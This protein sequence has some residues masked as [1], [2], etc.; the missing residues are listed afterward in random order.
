MMSSL[1]YRLT[2][3]KMQEQ[4]GDQQGFSSLLFI[5]EKPTAPSPPLR[6]ANWQS[7]G[8]YATVLCL[9]ISSKGEV[10]QPLNTIGE[11]RTV[12]RGRGVMSTYSI[13]EVVVCR[14]THSSSPLCHRNT[15]APLVGVWI[16]AL[17]RPQT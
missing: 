4:G 8:S 17:H 12:V 5:W 11:S 2:C 13:K 9:C 16:K 15:H 3:V 6:S 14:N 10:Y 7:K 1:E